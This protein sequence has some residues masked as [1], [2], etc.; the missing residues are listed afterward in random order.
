MIAVFEKIMAAKWRSVDR[1]WY[2]RNVISVLACSPLGQTDSSVY[3]HACGN[4]HT[5]PVSRESNQDVTPKCKTNDC[6]T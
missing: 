3:E 6:I 1:I 5:V 4:E 2:Q